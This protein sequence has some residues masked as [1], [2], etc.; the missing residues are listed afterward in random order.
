MHNHMPQRPGQIDFLRIGRISV[1][2][3]GVVGHKGHIGI[4]ALGNEIKHR[5]NHFVG[6][7]GQISPGERGGQFS[8]RDFFVPNRR[9]I[10]HRYSIFRCKII[11]AA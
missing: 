3:L 6:Q 11:S 10:E 7:A 4:R 5:I 8:D 1:S 9:K 2:G